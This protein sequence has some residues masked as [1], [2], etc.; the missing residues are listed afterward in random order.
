MTAHLGAPAG[1]S[2][3][4]SAPFQR[5]RRGRVAAPL[6]GAAAKPL[7]VLARI[8]NVLARINNTRPLR[9][10]YPM[11]KSAAVEEARMRGGIQQKGARYMEDDK[12][13]QRH[14]A[15]SSPSPTASAPLPDQTALRRILVPS[16]AVLQRLFDLTA[17]EARLA[18]SI[19]RGETLEEAAAALGVKVSTVRSQLAKLMIKTGTRRQGQLVALLVRVAYLAG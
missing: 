17:A 19:S 5:C 15:L 16:E 18:C 12:L 10:R 6:L 1:R 7:V 4:Q 14:I 2:Q 9:M 8:S 13:V 3:G 11:P